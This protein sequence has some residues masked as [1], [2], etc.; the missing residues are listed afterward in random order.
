MAGA[1]QAIRVRARAAVI[2]EIGGEGHTPTGGAAL[3][4]F[5]AL[6]EARTQTEMLAMALTRL[7]AL[8]A[9]TGRYPL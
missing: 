7:D 4:Q 3:Y 8:V 2:E 1:E 9:K 6:V 5:L